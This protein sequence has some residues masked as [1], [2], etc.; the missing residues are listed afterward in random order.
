MKRLVILTALVATT[1]FVSSCK[2]PKGNLNPQNIG[3]GRPTLI[4]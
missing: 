1:L 4:Q 3:K 2:S